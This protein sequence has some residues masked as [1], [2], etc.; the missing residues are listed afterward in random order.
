MYERLKE[1]V[2]IR[3]MAE[4]PLGAFLSGGVDSSAVVAIMSELSRE[5]VK[6]YSIGFNDPKYNEAE[7][8]REVAQHCRSDHFGKIV[9]SDDYDLIDTLLNVYDEPYADSTTLPTYRLC[10]L[11]STQV[12]VALSGDCV[13]EL[14]PDYRHH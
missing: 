2:D 10:E 1:A 4:V 13:G 8:A 14:M 9:D 7:F 11:A 6:T 12:T 3:L 5:A